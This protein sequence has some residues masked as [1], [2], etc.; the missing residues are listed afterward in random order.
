MRDSYSL[1]SFFRALDAWEKHCDAYLKALEKAKQPAPGV[2]Q[3]V[4][5]RNVWLEGWLECHA[6]TNG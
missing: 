2:E 6:E 4:G 1:N 5:Y 3:L